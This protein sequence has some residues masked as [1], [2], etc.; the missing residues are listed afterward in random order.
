MVEGIF[1]SNPD[2]GLRLPLICSCFVEEK[3]VYLNVCHLI[4]RASNASKCRLHGAE[5]V[6][7]ERWNT[8]KWNYLVYKFSVQEIVLQEIVGSFTH[9][10]SRNI[11]QNA[12]S[13]NEKVGQFPLDNCLPDNCHLGQ[14][15][16]RQLPPDNCSHTENRTIPPCIIATLDNCHQGQL[17]PD[18]S[19][20]GNCTLG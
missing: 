15:P 5:Y 20:S 16:P 7:C 18:N 19:P 4:I 17:P 1:N 9:F 13:Y 6:S 10:H 12:K 3:I 11:F 8:K 14:L 2:L